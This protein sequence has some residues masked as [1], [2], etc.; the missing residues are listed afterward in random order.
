MHRNGRCWAL[1]ALATASAANAQIQLERVEVVGMS[2][3]AGL[4]LPRDQIAANVQTA[5]AA[6]IERSQAADLTSFMNRRLGS[7]YLNEMQ[8]N[9][10]Q[11]DVNF[12]GYTASPLLGSQQGL[13]LYV[14]G[15]R[16][17]QPFGDVVSWDLVPKVAIA[18]VTLNPG[19]N[20]LFG[21][22]TLGGALSVQTKDGLKNAGSALQLQAGAF[23]RRTAEFEHGGSTDEGGHWFVAG[24]KFREDGWRVDSPSDVNQLFGKL[25]HRGADSEL[26]LSAALASTDLNGNGLQEQRLLARDRASVYTRPD[27]TKNRAA[28][29][30]LALS[31][32]LGEHWTLAGNAY[33]RAILSRSFNGDL[34]DDALG[35][36]GDAGIPNGVIHRSRTQQ[37]NAGFNAQLGYDGPL[38]GLAS[39][40]LLGAAADFSASHFTQDAELGD[41]NP[42]RSVSGSGEMPADSRVDLLGRTRTLSLFASSVLTLGPATHLSLSGRYNDSRLRNRDAINPGGGPGSLDGR[43]RFSRFNPAIG[44]SFDP[45]AGVNA[46]AGIGQGSRDPSSVE[47]GCA[48]PAN[49]CRLP[50]AFAG[51][52]PLKQVVTTTVE[53]GLRSAAGAPLAWNLGLFRSDNRDDLLF[54]A[55]DA[56]GFGYFKNFGRTRRQGI[57][58]GLSVQPARGLT[59]GANLTL[60]DASYRS[61]ETVNGASNSSNDTA[62]A[63]R[64]GVDGN[65][66]IRPGDRIPLVP[67][68]MLKLYADLDLGE[69]WSLGADAIATSGAP[70]RGNENG[71]HRPDGVYYLGPG[72]S[73]GHAVLNVTAAWKPAKGIKLFAQVANLLDRAYSTAAQLGPT[74]FDAAG[75]FQ[76]QPFPANAN[77]DHPLRHATFFAPGAPRS[78]SVGLK[79][80]F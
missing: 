43:Q 73:A 32:A 34:N 68:R 54:V 8:G 63:G 52:P 59:A 35:Q 30:N 44:L 18:S 25:G 1:L 70:A 15:V 48:D 36:P 26:T 7:V 74:G 62:S 53:A 79:L 24:N 72:R 71:Q 33:A 77:G 5:R 10:L 75:N 20:P 14:D 13:S 58:L 29:V 23:G 19:S 6:D 60:L 41:L 57:E 67:R 61:A 21:L 51:D 22:N 76:G 4:G 50:N 56:A 31:Q 78:V 39:K 16:L 28:L 2:P 69:A 17:N 37:R 46:W 42:D 49:P 55:D 80:G 47:L 45:V 38:L 64:P 27:N 40:S 9:P 65:I 11:P 66:A 12:R 3:V